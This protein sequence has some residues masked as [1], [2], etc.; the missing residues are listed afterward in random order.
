MLYTDLL[1]KNILAFTRY[2]VA[3]YKYFRRT[4]HEHP[5]TI[6]TQATSCCTPS[7]EPATSCCTPVE[8]TT[9]AHLQESAFA[10]NKTYPVAILGAG[11]I[12]L[13]AAAHLSLAGV[14]FILLE[15]GAE[16]AENIKSW[17]HVRLFSP[18]QYNIDKASKQLLL[19]SGWTM[20]KE[21]VLPT[22]QEIRE[23]YL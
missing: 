8:G 16:V 6:K 7:P 10:L 3:D 1:S 20:P 5:L 12:G 13:A 23:A 4:K 18:W 9:E 19:A 2:I 14:A 21:D 17:Q 22:G 11:P 15:K